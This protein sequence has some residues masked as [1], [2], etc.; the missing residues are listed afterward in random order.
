MMI[1]VVKG[2]QDANKMS[3]GRKDYK[4]MKDL[5]GGSENIKSTWLNGFR[6]PQL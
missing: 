2:R 6:Y 1:I 4:Y 5:M 3:H